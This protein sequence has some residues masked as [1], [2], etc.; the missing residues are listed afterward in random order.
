MGK[1]TISMDIFNSYVSHYQRVHIIC[2]SCCQNT[3]S[4][5]ACLRKPLT[6]SGHFYNRMLRRFHPVGQVFNIK[7]WTILGEWLV[8]P[9]FIGQIRVTAS[10]INHTSNQALLQDFFRYR[11]FPHLRRICFQPLFGHPLS[12]RPMWTLS[13]EQYMFC[14]CELWGHPNTTAGYSKLKW[15]CS[16]FLHHA[17]SIK[18]DFWYLVHSDMV[19][20]FKKYRGPK[21]FVSW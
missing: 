1:S 5:R 15:N 2:P 6:W 14:E 7:M 16:F 9:Y 19:I 21:V 10:S 20:R 3:R 18:V 4:G 11:F 12:W 13:I 8:N 17:N